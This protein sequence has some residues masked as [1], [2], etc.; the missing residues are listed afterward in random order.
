MISS[1][2]SYISPSLFLKRDEEKQMQRKTIHL[3][4]TSHVLEITGKSRDDVVYRH[5]EIIRVIYYSSSRAH[6]VVNFFMI[7]VL[8]LFN[9]KIS[10]YTTLMDSWYGV[11]IHVELLR[12]EKMQMKHCLSCQ[13]KQFMFTNW[14]FMVYGCNIYFGLYQLLLTPSCVAIPQVFWG[15]GRIG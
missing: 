10:G 7:L 5:L 9:S 6:G 4:Q 15:E 12:R 11:L 14:M 2:L 1:F 3:V 13:R 8:D